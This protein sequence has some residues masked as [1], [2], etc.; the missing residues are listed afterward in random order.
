MARRQSLAAFGATALKHKTT[1]LCTHSLAKS[2]SF[3]AASIVRLK[4]S[5]HFISALLALGTRSFMKKLRIN[6]RL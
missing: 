4:S 3:C 6:N 5:L 2:M 1:G